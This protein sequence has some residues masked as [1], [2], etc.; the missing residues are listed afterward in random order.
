MTSSPTYLAELN[1]HPRDKFIEF[2][3]LG[4]KYTINGEEGYTSVTTLIAKIFEHFDAD[5]IINK[6]FENPIKMADPKNKY[7]GM[8]KQDIKDAWAANGKDASEKG[9]AMHNNIEKYYNGIEVK[10]ESIE[11][12]YFKNFSADFPN[13]KAYRTEQCVYS[14]KHKICGS[15]DMQFWNQEDGTIDIYD[16]KRAKSI[17]YEPFQNKACLVPGLEHV[18]D[19]NFWHYALQ[20]NIYKFLLEANYGHKIKD[21]YL[22]ICHPDAKNYQRLQCPIMDDEIAIIMEWWSKRNE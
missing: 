6:M 10:D 21:L 9:T 5:K 18:A 15:I 4:H 7:F 8:S 14:E 12:G 16:W 17:E 22:V 20:T 11:Y 1:A 2:E 3:E 13:L 19:T